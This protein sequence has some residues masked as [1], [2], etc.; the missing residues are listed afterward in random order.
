MENTEIGK[1]IKARRKELKI[2]QKDLAQKVGIAEVTL[3]QYE[4]GLYMPKIETRAKLARA[5][6]CKYEDLFP[7]ETFFSLMTA[8]AIEPVQETIQNT[9]NNVV[10]DVFT[11]DPVEH[12]L[13][14]EPVE[15][16]EPKQPDKASPL[17]SVDTS[18]LTDYEIRELQIY[19]DFLIFRRGQSAEPSPDN[20]SN[21]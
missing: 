15:V 11:I 8:K 5:L 21:S 3:R 12:F 1:K 16:P 13:G 6:Q 20:S 17:P 9:L 4:A 18:D 10:K 2:T 19:R 14:S 7:S